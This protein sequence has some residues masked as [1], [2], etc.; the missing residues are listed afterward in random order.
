VNTNGPSDFTVV[1]SDGQLPGATCAARKKFR[2]GTGFV[3]LLLAAGTVLLILGLPGWEIA[4]PL[5]HFFGVSVGIALHF[6]FASDRSV[7]GLIFGMVA[8]VVQP[9]AFWYAV[10]WGMRCGSRGFKWALLFCVAAIAAW[11]WGFDA[12]RDRPDWTSRGLNPERPGFAPPVVL[13]AGTYESRISPN[14]SG[15][16]RFEFRM[17]GSDF[18]YAERWTGHRGRCGSSDILSLSVPEF[19]KTK[20]EYFP[21]HW[22]VVYRFK[23]RP[24]D[25]LYPAIGRSLW[26]GEEFVGADGRTEFSMGK[27]DVRFSELKQ[28]GRFQIPMRM[29]WSNAG[30]GEIL[31][32]R[33]VEFLTEPGT[34]WFHTIR[35]KHFESSATALRGAGT[36][37]NEAGWN[38]EIRR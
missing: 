2:L 13:L 20:A 12:Y 19:S 16:G 37:L 15:S 5:S 1:S 7:G 10:V 21:C 36:D 6:L 31:H 35:R 11:A 26:C 23:K 8:L 25:E 30:R 4:S 17:R 38:G 18:H 29:E 9:F 27:I 24:A 33:R 34:N 28:F 22:M 14:P 32:V 3:V